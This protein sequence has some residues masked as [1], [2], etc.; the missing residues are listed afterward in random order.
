ESRLFG[1]TIEHAGTSRMCARARLWR[2]V[3]IAVSIAMAGAKAPALGTAWAEP[4]ATDRIGG[5][6]P[7]RQLQAQPQ[8]GQALLTT[9]EI[10]LSTQFDLPVVQSHPRIELVPAAK[11][12]A[13]RYCG[14]N[15]DGATQPAL[16]ADFDGSKPNVVA[17]YSDSTRTI[18]LAEEW[19]GGTA[20]ELSV[21]VHEMGHHLQNVGGLKYE[22]PQAREQLP[23][24]AADRWL[25]L[26]WHSLVQDFQLHRVS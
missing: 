26:F 14:L 23:Y 25:A 24:T 2:G 12:A 11:I 13:M 22:C 19:T 9:I 17:V 7:S 18:Y 20:A 5:P 6:P 10:W 21:L 15:P 4:I 16:G 8:L 3:L 1:P